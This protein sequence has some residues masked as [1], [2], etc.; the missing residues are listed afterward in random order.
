MGIVEKLI[1]AFKRIV[2]F[3]KISECRSVF[4][5]CAG[6]LLEAPHA[7][8]SSTRQLPNRTESGICVPVGLAVLT[9][10]YSILWFS[11]PSFLV[12]AMSRVLSAAQVSVT[13][14]LSFGVPSLIVK[15]ADGSFLDLPLTWQRCGLVSITVFGLLF[16]LLMY[17]LQGRFLLK[18]AW[19]ELGLLMGLTWSL[20][21][22]S[23]AV[24]ISYHF[25]AG[26][27]TVADF[28]TGPLTDI[29]W[30]VAVWSLML[31]TSASRKR[32]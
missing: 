28:L 15:L 7:R 30:M 5:S 21:R 18:V 25:G 24:M 13:K 10:S 32:R 17:P 6:K 20:I 1:Y 12:E 3:N 11:F 16:L 14:T 19:L 29:F 22:L 9:V 31:S 4:Q 23:T 2:D 26:A 8:S 27:F